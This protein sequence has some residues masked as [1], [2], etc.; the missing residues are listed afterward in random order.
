[1]TTIPS[2]ARRRAFTLIELLVVIAIVAIL[3]GMLLPAV[4]LVREAARGIQC[5]NDLRM[6]QLANIAYASDY[7]GL[8]VPNYQRNADG[9]YD[10]SNWDGTRDFL[11]LWSEDRATSAYT[12]PRSMLC[13]KIRNFQR[14]APDW[15]PDTAMSFGY[16]PG[17][18]SWPPPSPYAASYRATKGRLPLVAAF[19]DALFSTLRPTNYNDY[20]TGGTPAPEG[21]KRDYAI[22]YR[23]QSKAN[24]VFYDGHVERQAATFF[25]STVPFY[26][27]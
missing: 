4:N 18:H 25:A 9:T 2:R 1:M 7:D 13:P 12:V 11:A 3:A 8:F 23:H 16:N 20:W 17:W 14:G 5:G 24:A 6:M 27:N 19:T 15:M 22:A 21:Y 26:G 10:W